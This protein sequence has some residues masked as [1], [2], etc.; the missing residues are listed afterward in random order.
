MNLLKYQMIIVIFDMLALLIMFLLPIQI[1]MTEKI[2]Y[3]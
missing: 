3:K 1:L 2:N